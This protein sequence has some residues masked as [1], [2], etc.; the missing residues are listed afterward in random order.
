MSLRSNSEQGYRGFRGKPC[1]RLLGAR[2]LAALGNGLGC[3]TESDS[4][5]ARR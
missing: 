2:P 5:G 3:V 1:R 4:D